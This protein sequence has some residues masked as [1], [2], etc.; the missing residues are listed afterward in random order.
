MVLH[1][2]MAVVSGIGRLLDAQ[3]E[4]PGLRELSRTYGRRA[5]YYAE[6]ERQ[7]ARELKEQGESRAFGLALAVEREKQGEAFDVRG[8]SGGGPDA[9]HSWANRV[10]RASEQSVWDAKEVAFW[11]RKA[12][13]YAQMRQKW[14]RS[15]FYPWLPS[16]R[17]RRCGNCEWTSRV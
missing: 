11:E 12:I 2:L 3:M 13:Y 10:S 14:Q 17:T 7:A 8:H 16:R 6:L 9:D 5:R 1:P 4:G 15:A